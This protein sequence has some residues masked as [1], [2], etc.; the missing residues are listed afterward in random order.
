MVLV[1][2]AYSSLPGS[3]LRCPAA[4]LNSRLPGLCP[5]LLVSLRHS[6]GSG[7]VLVMW[8]IPEDDVAACEFS[9]PFIKRMLTVSVLLVVNKKLKTLI[10]RLA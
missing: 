10:A 9:W 5:W 3:L 8:S 2:P 6:A 7:P 1:Q 4:S